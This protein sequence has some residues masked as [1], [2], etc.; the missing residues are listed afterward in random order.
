MKIMFRF[1]GR[2]RWACVLLPVFLA[3]CASAAPESSTGGAPVSKTRAYSV[4]NLAPGTGVALLNQRGQAAFA[5]YSAGVTINGFFDG[6]RVYRVGPDGGGEALISGL[7]DLGVVVGQFNDAS[8][9]GPFNLRAF[10]WTV[11][12]GLR[13]LPGAGPAIAR[14]INDR[15]QAVGSIKGTAFYGRAYRWNPDGTSVDLGPLPASLSE[16]IAINDLGVAV[17]YADVALHDSHAVVWDANGRATDLGTLGGTQSIAQYINAHG[18]VVGTYYRDGIPGGFLWTR[19]GGLVKIVPDEQAGV[20]VT[21]L[22]DGGEV[23]GNLQM[24]SDDFRYKPFIWST[25]RGRRPLPLAGADHGSVDALNNRNGMVGFIEHTSS[26][27]LGRRAVRWQ[28][29][30]N[31]VDLNSL[32]YHAPAGLVLYAG[33]AI[34][35]EGDILAD[36]NAGLVLLR[37]GTQGS[38]APVLGPIDTASANATIAVNTRVDFTVAF[39]DANPSDTHAA[40]A[41]IDDGCAQDVPALREVRGNGEV[42]VRHMFCRSGSFTIKVKVTD[43][44]GNATE[45]HRPVSVVD[46]P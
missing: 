19:D 15:N 11:A 27:P 33:K 37:P 20:R 24:A 23:A 35:D 5:T 1:T 38:D 40:S 39:I 29:L 16:A 41:S 13:A 18:Q 31:P 14:A 12:G 42:A 28:G 22:N 43:R 10:T 9:P 32:L 25:T 46:V 8:T 30:A 4:V 2:F 17:G 36:S 34:N 44:A 3:D 21:A 45:V 26:G 6:R 7:N